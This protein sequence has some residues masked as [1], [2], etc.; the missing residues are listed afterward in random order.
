MADLRP[1]DDRDGKI[2]FDGALVPWREANVHVLTHALHYVSES[3]GI[4]AGFLLAAIHNVGL[5]SLTHT[6]SPMNFLNEIC[7]RPPSEKPF[8][9]LVVGY[10]AEG[11]QVPAF[12]ARKK[13]L[14]EI[15]TWL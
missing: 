7:G 14:G 2:W 15:S 11:V 1:Y 10:P 6:P 5:V 12:A 13:P 9:L 4:A 8:L 3:V